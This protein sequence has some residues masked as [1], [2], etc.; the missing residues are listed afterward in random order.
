M[1]LINLFMKLVLNFLLSLFPILS[2]CQAPDAARKI[3][4]DYRENCELVAIDNESNLTFFIGDSILREA[5]S[6]NAF[7]LPNID[8][9]EVDSL[10]AEVNGRKFNL[11][12]DV[13]DTFDKVFKTIIPAFRF[14]LSYTDK[15]S[16]IRENYPDLHLSYPNLDKLYTWHYEGYCC[17]IMIITQ[18]E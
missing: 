10:V 11:Y 1:N 6:D 4:I 9:A 8:F 3:M 18:K 2:N 16:C 13:K 7:T 17:E 14:Y 5:I 12:P 15:N